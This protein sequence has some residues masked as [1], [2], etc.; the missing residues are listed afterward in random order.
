MNPA[1]QI[2][3]IIKEWTGFP[4]VVFTD[5][6]SSAIRL[7]MTLLEGRQKEVNVPAISCCTIAGSILEAGGIP[8]FYDL[9]GRFFPKVIAAPGEIDYFILPWGRSDGFFREIKPIRPS[10]VDLT[11]SVMGG[12]SDFKP[13]SSFDL[14][15]ISLGTGKPLDVGAGGLLLLNDKRLYLRAKHELFYG[16]SG[17]S[18]QSRTRRVVFSHLLF[19]PLSQRFAGA[20]VAGKQS[21]A[22]QEMWSK[23][24]AQHDL[25][26]S[27]PGFGEDQHP[28]YGTLIPLL[29]PNDF[30]IKAE[31]CYRVAMAE[32]L[33]LLRQPI[34]PAYLEPAWP[35]GKQSRCVTAEDLN[36]RLLFVPSMMEPDS[37]H[38]EQLASF[39]GNILDRPE[40]FQEISPSRLPSRSFPMNFSTGINSAYQE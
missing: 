15:I 4:Y 38:F 30:P 28:G 27:L 20:E 23:A 12:K 18:W 39:F 17:M 37:S 1:E 34:S 21:Q 24:V 3:S 22:N 13:A 6:G 31:T 29:L 11:L 5:S 25:P 36:Q 10:I 32:N 16:R 2:S 35:L 33:P 9:D 7:A 14:G 19:A 8:V 40:A 26:L